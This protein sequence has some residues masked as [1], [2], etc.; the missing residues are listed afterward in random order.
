[1]PLLSWFAS[2]LFHDF[3][4]ILIKQNSLLLIV[5]DVFFVVFGPSAPVKLRGN[6]IFPV[7]FR[8]VG[9]SYADKPVVIRWIKHLSSKKGRDSNPRYIV[10]HFDSRWQFLVTRFVTIFHLVKAYAILCHSNFPSHCYRFVP[11]SS[12]C[13]GWALMA[14]W[15]ASFIAIMPGAYL[16][17]SVSLSFVCS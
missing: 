4:L 1:M 11:T 14:L 7:F 6:R 9:F 16:K 8:T 17:M 13:S 10:G 12:P 3:L 15:L 5:P 2:S